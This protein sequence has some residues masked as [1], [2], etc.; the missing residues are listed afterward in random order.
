MFCCVLTPLA[1]G[2]GRR[3][4]AVKGRTGG[5]D[6]GGQ[7]Q[8]QRVVSP[9]ADCGVSVCQVRR[10]RPAR[11][12]RPHRPSCLCPPHPE[13]SQ[14]EPRAQSSPSAAGAVVSAPRPAPSAF[15]PPA[16][17]MGSGKGCWVI[18]PSWAPSF[19]LFAYPGVSSDSCLLSLPPHS[20]HQDLLSPGPRRYAQSQT[21]FT[22]C[23]ASAHL[24]DQPMYCSGP[25]LGALRPLPHP[26]SQHC[27][28][29]SI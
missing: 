12:D 25:Y 9:L 14:E 18:H 26:W 3:G 11:S 4:A 23:A 29:G 6:P 8:V 16:G 15:P 2:P 22:A 1:P 19:A 27:S 17:G 21:S 20:S 24:G 13:A 5:F 7:K 28:Q 10:E